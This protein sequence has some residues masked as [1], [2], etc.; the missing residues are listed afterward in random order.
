M[1]SGAIGTFAIG[2]LAIGASYTAPDATPPAPSAVVIASGAIGTFAIG[3]LAIGASEVAPD[4]AP[5]APVI[6]IVDGGTAGNRDRSG[7]ERTRSQHAMMRQ[8]TNL[9][10][11]RQADDEMILSMVVDF[12]EAM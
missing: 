10:A 12:V 6:V 5:P 11:L 4:A 7:F 1:L 3:T 2:V 9:I 8:R